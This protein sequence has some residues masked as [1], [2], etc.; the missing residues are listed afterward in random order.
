MAKTSTLDELLIAELRDLYSAETQFATSLPRLARAASDASLRARFEA[1]LA[2]TGGHVARLE[3]D[4]NPR[5]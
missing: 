1:H 2:Q 3:R 4:G 5:R